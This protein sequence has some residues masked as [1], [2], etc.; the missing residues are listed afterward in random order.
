[1][2]SSGFFS[3]FHVNHGVSMRV[4]LNRNYFLKNQRETKELFYLCS[5]QEKNELLCLK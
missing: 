2:I 5:L 4:Q 3:L 1:M